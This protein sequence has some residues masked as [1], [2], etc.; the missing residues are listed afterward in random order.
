MLTKLKTKINSNLKDKDFKEIVTGSSTVFAAMIIATLLGLVF[1]LLV[2]RIYG[3]ESMGILALVNSFLAIALLPSLFGFNTSV[4]R[5]IPE[6]LRKSSFASAFSIY[7]KM[8]V[9]VVIISLSVSV[10]LFFSSDIVAEYIFKKP[11]LSFL[12]AIV[13]F[14]I[15]IK[16]LTSFNQ[17]TIRAFKDIKYFSL[18]SVFAPVFNILILFLIT[19]FYYDK[20]TPVYAILIT[21]V[22]MLILTFY[23][24]KKTINKIKSKSIQENTQTPNIKQIINTSFPMFLTSAMGLVLTQTDIVMLGIFT[25]VEDVGVYAIVVKLALLTTFVLSSINAVI[26]PKFSEYYHSGDMQKLNNTVQKSAKL[27]FYSTLPIVLGLFVFGKFALGLFDDE[28]VLGY[29]ALCILLVG[30]FVNIASGSVGY[31]MN[32]T[33]Y[34]NEYNYIMIVSALVNV[35]LNYFLIP[36]YG[37]EGAA[38]AS[39]IS[40]VLWNVVSLIFMNMKIK[41]YTGYIPLRK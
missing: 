10:L 8:F 16:A 7:K 36:I 33:G 13:S 30:Q 35:V 25:S 27:I 26:A 32:M 40:M 5:F 21:S 28:F 18:L 38:I 17:S 29:I 34:Q 24:L 41:I 31:L 23:F 14:F 1:N 9:T 11:E 12:F 15:V 6:Y 22:L 37:I 3:T 20:S 19:Y 39:A 2:A 4:L